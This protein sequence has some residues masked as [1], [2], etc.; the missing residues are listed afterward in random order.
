MMTLLGNNYAPSARDV[1]LTT[2]LE[3]SAN[4][5]TGSFSR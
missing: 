1:Y 5:F 4:I 3:L 2:R